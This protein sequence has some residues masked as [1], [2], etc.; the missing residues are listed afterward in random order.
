[1]RGVRAE[2]QVA[3]VDARRRRSRNGGQNSITGRTSNMF[4]RSGR[5]RDRAN[6]RA[7]KDV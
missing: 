1:M 7:R 6:L 5:V 2:L 4:W 3:D